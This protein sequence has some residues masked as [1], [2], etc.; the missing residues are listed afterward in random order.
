MGSK[1]FDLTQ[2]SPMRRI[3]LAQDL[4]DSVLNDGAVPATK[5]E[6]RAEVERRIAQADAGQNPGITWS[7][8]KAILRIPR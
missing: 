5:P 8:A 1:D 4:W 3:L 2:L 7:E 6:Q